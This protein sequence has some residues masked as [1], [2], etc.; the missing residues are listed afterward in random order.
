M[1]TFTAIADY[2]LYS[3]NWVSEKDM[4]E[5]VEE[6]EELYKALADDSDESDE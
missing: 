6:N 1:E 4:A 2:L 3:M 5:D